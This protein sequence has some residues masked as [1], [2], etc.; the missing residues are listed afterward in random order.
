MPRKPNEPPIACEYF[1]WGLFRRNGV[2][3]A[4]GRGGKRNLGKHS[5]GTRDRDE[6]LERLK[7]LDRQKAVELGLA[8]ASVLDSTELVS[9]SDGWRLYL[10]HSDRGEV[11][12]GVSP[13]TLR[14]YESIRDNHIEFCSQHGV[15]VW[16]EFD[17]GMVQRFSKWLGKKH[18]ASTVCLELQ[19]VKSL[20]KWLIEEKKLPADCEI[21]LRLRRP[22]DSDTYCYS[23]DEVSR[24]VKH[25]TISP[26]LKWLGHVILALAHLGVRISELVGLRW[27]DI[28][29][30]SGMIHIADE[31]SSRRKGKAGTARTTKGRRSRSIP[32]HPRLRKAIESLGPNSSGFVFR[33]ANGK[34]LCPGRV[35][36]LFIREVI[37]PLK[38]EFPTPAGENGFEHGRLHSFRHFFCSQAFLGGASEGEIREWLGHANSRMVERYRHLRNEDAQRRMAQIEF[39]AEEDEE[40]PPIEAA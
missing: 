4:D 20:V 29:L 1:I 5:L 13:P 11:L 15:T 24:M 22:Q 32:I 14:R 40:D 19:T 3:Y 26:H 33:D 16:N 2:Y 39:L 34:A 38:N 35:L 25:C 9:I 8:D 30:E 6:A 23:S 37:E 18:A 17:K 21:K 28:H 31:R 27:S 12:S 10:E 7:Q 36:K